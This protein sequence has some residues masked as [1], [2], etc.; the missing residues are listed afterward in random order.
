VTRKHWTAYDEIIVAYHLACLG[1]YVP[2]ATDP[3]FDDL[4]L[5]LDARPAAVRWKMSNLRS[6]RRDWTGAPTNASAT[7]RAVAAL[8]D[9][10]EASMQK[11]GHLLHAFVVEGRG[12]G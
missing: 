1:W 8:F 12:D 4:A 5:V 3:I 11:V 10:D 6:V 9:A 2:P 7:S